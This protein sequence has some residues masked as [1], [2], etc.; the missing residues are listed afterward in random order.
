MSYYTSAQQYVAADVMSRPREWLVPL[1]YEHLLA[2]LRRAAV[3]IET[4]DLAGKAESISRAQA[5]ILELASTLDLEHG[6]EIA[7]HLSSLYAFF[8]S[9]LVSASRTLDTRTLQRLIAMIADLHEAWVRAA[10]EVAP[11]G[12]SAARQ[13]GYA[14]A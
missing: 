1:L 7:V 6:G 2:S 10:E 5:I 12:R 4:G 8:A 13:P 3:Q 14:S 9:E 11:R